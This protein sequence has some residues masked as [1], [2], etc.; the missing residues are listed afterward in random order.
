MVAPMVVWTVD[1]RVA[2]MAAMKVGHLVVEKVDATAGLSVVQTADQLVAQSV[3]SRVAL[4]AAL[5]VAHLAEQKV[6][7]TAGWMA[8]LSV[9]LKAEQWVDATAGQSAD[10]MAV[11][12]VVR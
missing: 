1:S 8:A 4:M 10:R 9:A 5:R 11:L 12:S 7:S 3:D 2:L 6:D